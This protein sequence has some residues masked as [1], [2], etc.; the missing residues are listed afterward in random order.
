MLAKHRKSKLNTIVGLC[1]FLL[2]GCGALTKAPNLNSAERLK[3]DNISLTLYGVE[4]SNLIQLIVDFR[5]ATQT[6]GMNKLD[7]GRV[8][9]A[10]RDVPADYAMK[11]ILGCYGFDYVERGNLIEIV[12]IDTPTPLIEC[13][14]FFLRDED[15]SALGT[16]CESA[17]DIAANPK[18]RYR[19]LR[20]M[21]YCD[22]QRLLVK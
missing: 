16:W 18:S 3:T 9:L 1:L 15:A 14:A 2:V 13:A 5:G 12:D 7:G 20:G 6:D 4:L 11:S 21:N 19:D 22:Y 10:V 8:T 17:E